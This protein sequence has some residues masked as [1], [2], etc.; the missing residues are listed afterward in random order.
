MR[1]QGQGLMWAQE[2]LDHTLRP[3][4]ASTSLVSQTLSAQHHPPGGAAMY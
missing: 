2:V 4:Q 1:G 3:C